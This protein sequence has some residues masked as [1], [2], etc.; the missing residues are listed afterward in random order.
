MQRK[1]LFAWV[2]LLALSSDLVWSQEASDKSKT[3]RFRYLMAGMKDQREKLETGIFRAYGRFVYVEPKRRQDEQIDGEVQIFCAFDFPKDLIRIDSTHPVSIVRKQGQPIAKAKN[4]GKEAKEEKNGKEGPN[5]IEKTNSQTSKFIHTP[6]KSFRHSSGT[7]LNVTII[8][9]DEPAP[10][11]TNAFDVRIVGLAV[12]QSYQTLKSFPELYKIYDELGGIAVVEVENE[13]KGIYR[14]SFEKGDI[15]KV[16]WIDEKR[17]FSPIRLEMG[18]PNQEPN[19]T[20]EG[21]WIEMEGVWVPKTF[22]IQQKY[23][24]RLTSYALSFEWEAINKPIPDKWFT[25]EGLEADQARLLWD[26]RIKGKP[27]VV[28]RLNEKGK[29]T[30]GIFGVL[31]NSWLEIFWIL[32]LVILVFVSVRVFLWRRKKRS[33]D[34]VKDQ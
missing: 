5:D 26:Y 15:K 9:S 21:T 17:G 33:N 12:L 32:V 22:R 6:A 11:G 30:K 20:S 19:V 27:I 29:S 4:K 8:G 24:G 10:P 13:T 23:P 14:M 28:G 16:V 31:G 7:A 1:F 18:P 3:A 34:L 2:G 25:V